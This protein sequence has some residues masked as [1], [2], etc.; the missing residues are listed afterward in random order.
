MI[1]TA[2]LLLSALAVGML[3]GATRIG[4][5]LLIP[6]LVVFAGLGI[7]EAMATALFTF[8]FTGIAGSWMFQRRGS[9]DWRIT[10]WICSGAALLGFIGSWIN[11]LS[12]PGIL[13]V[14]LAVLIIF[15]GT[16]ALVSWR[17]VR[18]PLFEA[19]SRSEQ[20]VL[21]GIGSIAGFGSGLTGAGGPVLSVP[22]MVLFGFPA[23][24]AVGTSQVLQIV[25]ATSGTLGSLEFGTVNFMVAAPV[26]LCEIVGVV[27]GVRVSHAVHGN[28]LRA[29]VCV[30]CIG[31]GLLLLVRAF[32]HL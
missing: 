27:L 12:Q 10:A 8:I 23:L 11:S 4:G 32:E 20:S 18:Q 3:I 30:L 21:A 2:W 22:L 31:I 1:P 17:G 6:A 5:V 9:I 19:R 29:C 24:T 25:S 28:T 16:N 15:A 14:L 13:R 7:H 26:T